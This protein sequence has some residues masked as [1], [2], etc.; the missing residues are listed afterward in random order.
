VCFCKDVS[1]CAEVHSTRPYQASILVVMN[2]VS[3][4]TEALWFNGRDL[5][6]RSRP[7]AASIISE[8]SAYLLCRAP[9]CRCCAAVTYMHSYKLFE[10]S[11]TPPVHQQPSPL[12]PFPVGAPKVQSTQSTECR[13]AGEKSKLW[14]QAATQDTLLCSGVWVCLYGFRELVKPSE[15]DESASKTYRHSPFHT[16]DSKNTYVSPKLCVCRCS[17]L[18]KQVLTGKQQQCQE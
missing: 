4:F 6:G 7:C 5:P 2:E 3:N 10:A 18:F 14:C 12:L 17:R 15:A 16:L 1:L 8:T 13:K 9:A 11:L